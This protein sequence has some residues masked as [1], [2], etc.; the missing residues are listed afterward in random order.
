[1]AKS[2]CHCKCDCKSTTD[3]NWFK[4]DSSWV[5]ETQ[6]AL[7]L[8]ATV[9]ATVTFQSIVDQPKY[10]TKDFLTFNTIAFISA[11]S[12][13]LLLVS[14]LPL[15]TKEWAW[16]LTIAMS[17]TVIFIALTYMEVLK[18]WPCDNP[19]DDKCPLKRLK[20][21]GTLDG[22]LEYPWF[23]DVAPAYYGS[24]IALTAV[25]GF[26]FF[27]HTAHFI[28]FVI[29]WAL[30]GPNKQGTHEGDQSKQAKPEGEA[31]I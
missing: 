26:V 28:Y 4:T 25:S 20:W 30:Y 6:G 29:M 24:I 23:E 14:G 9:I 2:E 22:T 19:W 16:P 13:I 12:I 3:G 15:K 18:T 7:M 17:S 10:L 11:L 8:V 1:M 31:R 5:K 27:A 21:N